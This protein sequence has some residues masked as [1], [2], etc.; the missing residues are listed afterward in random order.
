MKSL[1]KNS[2]LGSQVLI[3]AL[4]FS[5]TILAQVDP[6]PGGGFPPADPCDG[7]IWYDRVLN[8]NAPTARSGFTGVKY[9]FQKVF[10]VNGDHTHSDFGRLMNIYGATYQNYGALNGNS[11]KVSRY[12][13]PSDVIMVN[14]SVYFI[15]E[16]GYR[17]HSLTWGP[18]GWVESVVNNSSNASPN[19]TTTG[20]GGC[21]DVNDANGRIYYNHTWSGSTEVSAIDGPYAWQV[22][23]LDAS[24][25]NSTGEIVKGGWGI[26]YRGDDFKLKLKA[27]DSGSGWYTAS[28]GN[29][30]ELAYWSPLTY[31]SGRVFY[32]DV[33]DK[34]RYIDEN[35]GTTHAVLNASAPSPYTTGRSDM[36][37]SNNKLVYVGTDHRIHMM[38][39]NAGVWTHKLLHP[40][41][42]VR[43]DTKMDFIDGRGIVY[44]GRYDSKIHELFTCEDAISFKK[45]P[46]STLQEETIELV[47]FTMYPNPAMD[48]VKIAIESDEPGTILIQNMTGQTIY[49]TN[50]GEGNYTE[51]LDI[52]DYVKGIYIVKLV[53]Q[54]GEQIAIKKLV[55]N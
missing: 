45:A 47:S 26:Y 18:S 7:S 35:T 21:F 22:S 27:W 5:S 14:S 33:N 50:F 8:E 42:Q 40:T 52:N 36:V 25:S 32:I 20:F 28:L 43:D 23:A 6:D 55:K 39:Y 10:Y 17:L 4:L 53:S 51:T 54:S 12:S 24:G 46:E 3:G 34:I 48:N 11:T 19:A 44:V 31:A 1:L 37:A 2:Q 38:T 15:S 41:A 49:Q 30:P 13:S 9:G 16:S 29:G